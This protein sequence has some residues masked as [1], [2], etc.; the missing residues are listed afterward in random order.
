MMY[1]CDG[2]AFE[3]R[4][5]KTITRTKQLVIRDTQYT[6]DA[7]IVNRS[8]SELQDELSLTDAQYTR[9]G[10]SMNTDKSEVMRRTVR[11]DEPQVMIRNN[12]L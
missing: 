2:G 8:A 12:T 3:L 5:L 4:R 6:D 10:L 11:G 9:L 7:A 1:R